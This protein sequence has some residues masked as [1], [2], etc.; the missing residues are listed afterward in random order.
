MLVFPG[1]SKSDVSAV[2]HDVSCRAGV[3]GVGVGSTDEQI[4]L[5][6]KWTSP[7]PLKFEL[8]DEVFRAKLGKSARGRHVEET[9]SVQVQLNE[10]VGVHV[11][12]GVAQTTVCVAPSAVGP[13]FGSVD[14]VIACIARALEAAAGVGARRAHVALLRLREARQHLQNDS[15][16]VDIASA[17]AHPDVPDPPFVKCHSAPSRLDIA[18]VCYWI[19]SELEYKCHTE[20][21]SSVA[22]SPKSMVRYEMSPQVSRSVAEYAADTEYESGLTTPS[23]TAQGLTKPIASAAGHPDVPCPLKSKRH[24][25][26][27]CHRI[28]TFRERGTREHARLFTRELACRR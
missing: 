7:A 28:A 2:V 10:V 8:N 24:S 13:W 14:G 11:P 27:C 6:D 4:C 19:V 26:P 15:P 5:V 3:R 25:P 12:L 16:A 21:A 1:H 9:A 20:T 18:A 23:T 17:A 22:D